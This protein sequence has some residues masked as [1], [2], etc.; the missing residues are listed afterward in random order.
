[1]ESTLLTLPPV[2]KLPH[3]RVRVRDSLQLGSFF[4]LGSLLAPFL[5]ARRPLLPWI[6][7]ASA[8]AA[9]GCWDAIAREGRVDAILLGLAAYELLI[10]LTRGPAEHLAEAPGSAPPANSQGSAKADRIGDV[11]SPGF[12]L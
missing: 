12:V 8:L 4:S 7:V 2:W 5:P 1:M 3:E 6:V 10:A 11:S 9:L